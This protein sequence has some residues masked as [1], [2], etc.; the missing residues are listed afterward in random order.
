MAQLTEWYGLQPEEPGSNP[1]IGNISKT[2]S[3]YFCI[4]N[5]KLLAK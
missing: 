2:F 3:N 1:G 4:K 5:Y